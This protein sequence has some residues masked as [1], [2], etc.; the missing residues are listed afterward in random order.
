[1]IFIACWLSLLEKLFILID[2][3]ENTEIYKEKYK[4]NLITR[5]NNYH[6]VKTFLS[7]HFIFLIVFIYYVV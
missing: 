3:V 1:M 6:Y 7:L 4:N 5:C 2:Y